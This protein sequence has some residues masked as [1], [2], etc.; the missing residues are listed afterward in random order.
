MVGMEVQSNDEQCFRQ[1][2]QSFFPMLLRV[3][4][5]ITNNED[6]AE[7]VCQET[8]IRFYDK[9]M[10]FPSE[11]DAKYWLIRVAKNLAINQVKRRSRELGM[12]EKLKKLPQS[13]QQDGVQKLLEKETQE[14]VRR[15]IAQLPEKFR[16][17]IVMKEYTD[18]DYK[19]IGQTLH[20]SVSNVKVRAFRAR[21]MLEAALRR[22]RE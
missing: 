10:T 20:I 13:P 19:Q 16:L 21:K 15:A 9:A 7:E 18:M 6:M 1:V 5:H 11:D 17:V 3:V 22:S 14:E 12:V 8:F 2:Y 4:Y